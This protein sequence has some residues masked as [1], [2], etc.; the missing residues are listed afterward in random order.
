MLFQS[1]WPQEAGN[2]VK[3]ELMIRPSKLWSASLRMLS[4]AHV[5]SVKQ[6]G[7]RL[8]VPSDTIQL[9]SRAKLHESCNREQSEALKI[10]INIKIFMHEWYPRTTQACSDFGMYW[11]A[12]TNSGTQK[13]LENKTEGLIMYHTYSNSKSIWRKVYWIIDLES[14]A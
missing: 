7:T 4:L 3:S 13:I 11:C 14:H 6:T 2:K 5:C 1:L 9:L 8:P 10:Y 12:C